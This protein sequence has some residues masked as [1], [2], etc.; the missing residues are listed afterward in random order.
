VTNY[1]EQAADQVER[2]SSYLQGNDLGRLVGDV[3]RF[4]RRQPAVFLGGMFLAG[5]IGARFLKSS[6]PQ[7]QYD[8]ERYQGYGYQGGAPGYGYQGVYGSGMGGAYTPGYGTTDTY[9]S[10]GNVNYGTGEIPG[11]YRPTGAAEMD[12]S[13]VDEPRA[14]TYGEPLEE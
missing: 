7:P 12:R 11:V 4:A 3:E 6:Q 9:G 13:S 2:L 14:R 1:I 10:T 5:L 8:Y